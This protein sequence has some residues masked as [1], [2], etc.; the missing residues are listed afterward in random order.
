MPDTISTRYSSNC[1]DS[2]VANFQSFFADFLRISCIPIGSI[3]RGGPAMEPAQQREPTAGSFQSRSRCR[4]GE[5]SSAL[6][7]R[8]DSRLEVWS[9]YWLSNLISRRT[10]NQSTLSITVRK[11]DDLTHYRLNSPCPTPPHL[12]E[13]TEKIPMA[14][15]DGADPGGKAACGARR[16]LETLMIRSISFPR[17]DR[18][19]VVGR[20]RRGSRSTVVLG[21]W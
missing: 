5:W 4:S 14:S 20:R 11:T 17:A 2:R 15:H 21:P 6:P 7:K 13:H 8:L 10:S 3:G 19:T 16:P 18:K 12:P 1:V 9:P